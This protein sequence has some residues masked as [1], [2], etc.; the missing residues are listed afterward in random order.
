[1]EGDPLTSHLNCNY[2]VIKDSATESSDFFSFSSSGF[3]SLSDL[4]DHVG[5]ITQTRDPHGRR[6]GVRTHAKICTHQQMLTNMK[7]A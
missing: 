6:G 3:I 5:V 2:M 7:K 1:M 4:P